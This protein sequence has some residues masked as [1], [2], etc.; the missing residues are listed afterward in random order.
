MSNNQILPKISDSVPV[1]IILRVHIMYLQY[2]LESGYAFA[3]WKCLT[4]FCICWFCSCMY[5]FVSVAAHCYLGREHQKFL[6]M[7]LYL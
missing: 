3:F 2:I 5:M 1:V 6:F 4:D 7:N